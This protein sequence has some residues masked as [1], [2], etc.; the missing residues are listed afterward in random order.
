MTTY[1]LMSSHCI[2]NEGWSRRP[3]AILQTA[4]SPAENAEMKS[5]RRRIWDL[6]T[7]LYRLHG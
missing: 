3:V 6:L 2:S 5:A 7:L 4:K 1:L